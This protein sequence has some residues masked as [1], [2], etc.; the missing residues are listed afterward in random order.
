LFRR[1][2]CFIED[3]YFNCA[4]RFQAGNFAGFNNCPFPILSTSSH[5]GIVGQ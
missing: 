2:C 4:C 3:D 5:S 1:C